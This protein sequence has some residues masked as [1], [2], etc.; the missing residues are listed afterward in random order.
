MNMPSDM[1]QVTPNQI[2]EILRDTRGAKAVTI[3]AKTEVRLKKVGKELFGQVFKLSRVNG[4]IN[5]NY[6][7]AVNRQREREGGMADFESHPRQWGVRLHGTP[8]VQH[9]ENLY[10]ELKVEKSV[11]EPSYVNSSG[12]TVNL[13]LIRDHL[14][15]SSSSSRQGV[16][17][18]IILRDYKMESITSITMNKIT[19]II[20]R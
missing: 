20:V 19:Y 2:E 15:T 11:D 3:T 8:F 17:K 12:E 4:M 1:R 18:E 6:E 7:G 13:S 5:W 9:N 14:P 16:E 10:L